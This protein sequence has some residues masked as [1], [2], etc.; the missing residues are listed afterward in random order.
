MRRV[1]SL[2]LILCCIPILGM[3]MKTGKPPAAA[4]SGLI[5]SS[6]AETSSTA[7]TANR[8]Y[9]TTYTTTT[10][11]TIAYAHVFITTSDQTE[12]ICATIWDTSGNAIVST[13]STTINVA[14]GNWMNIA[15]SSSTTIAAA[16]SY[17][18]GFW[19]NDVFSVSLI[20]D[21]GAGLV[22]VD[23]SSTCGSSVTDDGD[24]A[25]RNMRVVFD[26]QSGDPA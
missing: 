22:D 21:L 16:T 1:I 11:G 10:A 5:G 14:N 12:N 3:Q 23:F 6:A 7:T 24:K 9:W 8:S 20:G 4:S 18:L 26:N 19:T 2:I 17:R 15:L 13:G 25:S